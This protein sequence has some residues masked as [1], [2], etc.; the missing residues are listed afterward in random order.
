MVR[1]CSHH[2][3][4]KTQLKDH[5]ESKLKFSCTT[6]S[7]RRIVVRYIRS[8]LRR[9]KTSRRGERGVAAGAVELRVS[10]LH[11][12]QK[13]KD[14]RTKLA[15]D[16]FGELPILDHRAV[17]CMKAISSERISPHCSRATD[18]GR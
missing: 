18:C 8:R 6:A 16:S 10:I 9:A 15:G 17:P 7:K 14:L 2:R 4:T 1:Y 12:V 3:D 11:L 5:L 13:I